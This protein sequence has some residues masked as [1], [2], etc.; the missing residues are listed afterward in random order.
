MISHRFRCIFIHQ[1]KNAGSSIIDSFGLRPEDP[2]W[3]VHNDGSL[4][5]GW[6]ERDDAIRDYLVFA[7]VR[8]P[9]DRFVSGWKYLNATRKR[10]LLEVLRDSPGNYSPHDVRHLW[11]PQSDTLL[12]GNGTLIPDIVLRYEHLA[13]DYGLLCDRIG[14]TDRDLPHLNATKHRRYRV[15]YD[16]EARELLHQHFK[17]DID[18]LGYRF[19]GAQ[20]L[21]S[22]LDRRVP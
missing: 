11:R 5:P 10:P 18:L 16:V 21:S 7:V 4:S 8:N 17:N 20:K 6:Y 13:R 9:W 22:D 1:R 15:L 2:H 14:K 3:H 12:D 19:S